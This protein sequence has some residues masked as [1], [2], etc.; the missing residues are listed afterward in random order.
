MIYN[1][2]PYID[3]DLTGLKIGDKIWTIQSGWTCISSI[4][5]K[6]ITTEHGHSYFLDGKKCI[7]DLYPSAFIT[8]PKEFDT[9][10]FL[11]K[12]EVI[13]YGTVKFKDKTCIGVLNSGWWNIGLQN[14]GNWNIGSYNTGIFNYGSYNSG[15][16][17][18][19]NY[20]TGFFNTQQIDTIRVF[21]KPCKIIDWYNAIKP[22]F[23]Y[24]SSPLEW[25]HIEDMT[26]EEKEKH[27][28]YKKEKGYYKILSH[29]VAIQKAW[30]NN[31]NK[32]SDKKLLKNLPN[33]DSD[34]FF[35]ITGI[36]I[37]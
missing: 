26:K 36:T 7:N 23:I 27:P 29:K 4:A 5:L 21:N 20:E 8:P 17:N 2:I 31:L 34:I 6:K 22:S 19:C 14:S 32:E 35:Q 18:I 9:D 3:H 13:A 33:F 30:N 1:K 10:L 37:T 11:E 12:D 25:V 28:N 16:W 15:G 24:K